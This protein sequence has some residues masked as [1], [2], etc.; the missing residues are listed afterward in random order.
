MDSS[1][2][3]RFLVKDVLNNEDN[4]KNAIV[5]ASLFALILLSVVF[6]L[7]EMFLKPE[8]HIFKI[9]QYINKYIL[10]L[11]IIEYSVRLWAHSKSM[12]ELFSF[13][14]SPFS[15]IDLL[16]LMPALRV[17]RSIR[18]LKMLRILRIAKLGRYKSN[19]IVLIESIST[20]LSHNYVQFLF[21][22]VIISS[23]TVIT[24]LALKIINPNISI[25]G[26]FWWSL[27]RVIDPGFVDPGG[28]AKWSEQILSLF[29]SIFGIVTFGLFIGL[30][31]NIFMHFF[32]SFQFHKRRL[33]LK[34]HHLL[35]NW[36]NSLMMKQ[37]IEE[38]YYHKGKA[39][40]LSEKE[41]SEVLDSFSPGTYHFR[42][43]DSCNSDDLYDKGALQKAR[44][45]IIFLDKSNEE[46]EKNAD[47]RTMLTIMNIQ[48]LLGE[49]K[50]ILESRIKD[51]DKQKDEMYQLKNKKLIIESESDELNDLILDIFIHSEYFD[52]RSEIDS[53]IL[54]WE[55]GDIILIQKN[56]LL[57][58]MLIQ[59]GTNVMLSLVYNE[60]LT[61]YG[62]E[63]DLIT[64]S[65]HKG[66][67]DEIVN[68]DFLE[69]NEKIRN[70][71]KYFKKKK[72]FKNI[73][74]EYP[75]LIVGVIRDSNF[76]LVPDLDFRIRENDKLVLLAD[77]S[78]SSQSQNNKCQ[79]T[80]EIVNSNRFPK[81]LLVIGWNYVVDD[82]IFEA[83]TYG[84]LQIFIVSKTSKYINS[85]S[86]KIIVDDTSY[87]KKIDIEIIKDFEKFIKET[88]K[89][90]IEDDVVN[91]IY[92]NTD[93]NDKKVIE[94]LTQNYDIDIIIN[95]ADFSSTG[96][97]HN[98]DART[99]RN[100]FF[101]KKCKLKDVPVIAEILDETNEIH[102]INA[103]ANAILNSPKYIGN[104][105]IQL[106]R[107]TYIK[108]ILNQILSTEGKE[109]YTLSIESKYINKSISEVRN[110]LYTYKSIFLIGLVTKNHSI[111][112]NLKDKTII[113]ENYNLF[114][115]ICNQCVAINY[116]KTLF[117]H[118]SPIL[119]L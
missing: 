50:K 84:I 55:F 20:F 51:K 2:S 45:I 37:L 14:I 26:A 7:W 5:E 31:S 96:D 110:D 85:G 49:K 114:I 87:L 40:I 34:E 58:Q 69:V 109:I 11:F 4:P 43:G 41:Q 82:I 60:L 104:Y 92:I 57:A 30:S 94:S 28:A 25:I 97:N 105:I 65:E 17:F 36:G 77:V 99:I 103:G 90:N 83:I 3:I 29:I 119:G 107:N 52:K 53:G 78:R 72:Y 91:V 73:S 54:H 12:K 63:F 71:F 106:T 86:R 116:K 59:I 108:L 95:V 68:L 9:V 113:N 33:K 74:C 76:Y 6:I 24:T 62:Q 19:I 117:R 38:L 16:C 32:N 44:N 47:N 98:S 8:T 75:P 15:I 81:I 56:K 13:T 67:S 64:I 21:L 111:Y 27:I 93:S 118:S 42:T 66:L 79:F 88:N 10:F 70:D 115:V 39:A 35:C 112:L 61:H 102:A 48:K 101:L 100:L 46:N 80:S 1:K 22:I 18:I 23:M 89:K